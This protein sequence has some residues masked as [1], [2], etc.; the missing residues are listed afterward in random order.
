LLAVTSG[1]AD[2]AHGE[3]KMN[4]RAKVLKQLVRES[5]Y[6]VDPDAV[7]KAIVARLVAGRGLPDVSFR[8]TPAVPRVREQDSP[9]AR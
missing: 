3:A 1:G 6:V 8:S 9:D 4:A 2:P 7:A 5:Q